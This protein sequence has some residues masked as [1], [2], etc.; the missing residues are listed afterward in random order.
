[1]ILG[2]D[3][4]NTLVCYDGLFHAEALRRGLLPAHTPTDKASVRQAL[5]NA[6]RDED[7]TVLQGHVYGPGMGAAQEYAGAQDALRDLIRQGVQ[8][9]IV[10]HKTRY[11]YLGPRHDMHA[12]AQQW[13]QQN[14][15]YAA[16][17]FTPDR[18]FLEP[19]KEDKLRRIAALACTHFLD[20]LPEFLG[21]PDFPLDVERLLFAPKGAAAAEMPFVCCDSWKAVQQHLCTALARETVGAV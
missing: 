15:F 11:P 3:F 18:V 13:L 17:L 4:D 2:V 21:H 9:Y 12:A 5:R 14:G 6:G 1:M 8:V 7:F 10:S 20:D 16:G 19:T